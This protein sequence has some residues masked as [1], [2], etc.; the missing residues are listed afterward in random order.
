[1]NDGERWS[2]HINI[3]TYGKTWMC[4][5]R[6]KSCFSSVEKNKKGK[7]P[8]RKQKRTNK[9]KESKRKKLRKCGKKFSTG[10][11]KVC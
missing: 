4:K 11:G 8:G 2:K 5:S 3:G 1:M 10:W 9:I 6:D 7:S